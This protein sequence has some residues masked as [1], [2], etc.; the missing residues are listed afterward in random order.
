MHSKIDT[1]LCMGLAPILPPLH[2][3]HLLMVGTLVYYMVAA[4][5]GHPRGMGC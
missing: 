2:Q 1:V 4:S 3:G 5:A